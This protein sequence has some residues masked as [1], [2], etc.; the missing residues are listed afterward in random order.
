MAPANSIETFNP[1][2]I[3]YLQEL[4]SCWRC[5]IRFTRERKSDVYRRKIVVTYIPYSFILTSNL[6][7]QLQTCGECQ[8]GTRRENF[9]NQPLCYLPRISS[10]SFHQ[11]RVHQQ[12]IFMYSM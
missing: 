3:E 9:K 1:Q 2:I 8:A 5:A 7:K 12:C 4:G 10:R 6:V 11:G